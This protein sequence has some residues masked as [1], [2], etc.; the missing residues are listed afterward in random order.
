[1][2]TIWIAE[3]KLGT[4]LR[5]NRAFWRGEL[6]EY[7][8]LWFPVE[9]A[10]P[11]PALPEIWPEERMWTDIE[12]V[13]ESTEN[14]LAGTYYGGDSLPIYCPWFG[15][16]QVAAWLGAEIILKPRENTSWVKP[17]V[18]DWEEHP[19]LRIDPENELWKRYLEI[20]RA[21][22]ER[23]KG[24]WVTGYPDLHTGIDALSAIR[25]P[26]HLSL[27]LLT[28]PG[29]IERAMI[30]MT[31][32]WKE[33][34]DTITDIIL[35]GGQGTTNWTWGWSDERYLCVGQNDYTCM[36]SREM[37]DRFCLADNIE[38]CRHVDISLYHLDGVGALHHLDTILGIEELDCVQWIW[39]NGKPPGSHW[40][41][42]LRQMQAAGKLVQVLYN[43]DLL[44]SGIDIRHEIEVLCRALDPSRLCIVAYLD[45]ARL[46]D[47]LV[48]LAREICAAKRP[49]QIMM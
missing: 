48:E 22:V 43:A 23:G 11:M 35:P 36:I 31:R 20:Y 40:I 18:K 21:A 41:D 30:Q 45:D 28:N 8:L 13:M 15:P 7:P 4:K 27:D 42:L 38:C 19:E 14:S 10:R 49:T 29:P 17:F 32:L 3:N 5:R 46:A 26:D 37:Y 9:G 1:M 44:R 16:D 39:G 24:N 47:H 34:V 2:E 25:G 12:Y 33:I 6:E